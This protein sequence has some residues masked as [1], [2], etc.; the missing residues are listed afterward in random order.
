[1]SMKLIRN[2]VVLIV[3]IFS[4]F[5][6]YSF[7]KESIKSN[8]SSPLHCN[9]P[10]KSFHLG[11]GVQKSLFAEIG[12]SRSKYFNLF[13]HSPTYSFYGNA[14]WVPTLNSK[15]DPNIF[16][17]K[18]GSK[19]CLFY[20]ILVAIEASYLTTGE[21]YSIP[22]TPK[23]GLFFR[24]ISVFYGYNHIVY[25]YQYSKIGTNQFSIQLNLQTNIFRK[26]K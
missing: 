10:N 11:L 3:F 4:V 21:N 23:I 17:L 18:A 19:I 24:F 14:V 1:M 15:K 13:Q 5:S 2:A 22:V 16:G 7:T 25:G 8:L 20:R 26:R 12:F 9:R 6:G